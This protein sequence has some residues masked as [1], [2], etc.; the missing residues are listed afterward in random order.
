ML[1]EAFQRQN[2]YGTFGPVFEKINVQT[3]FELYVLK[4]LRK[5]FKQFKSESELIREEN[6]QPRT[7]QVGAPLEEQKFNQGL[8]LVSYVEN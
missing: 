6:Y 7:A 2:L 8:A 4:W 5:A 1:K 3:L